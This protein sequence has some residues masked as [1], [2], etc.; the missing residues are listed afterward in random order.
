[1][2][3]DAFADIL[4]LIIWGFIAIDLYNG[5]VDITKDIHK[6]SVRHRISN[7]DGERALNE[8]FH[9]TPKPWHTSIK[10]ALQRKQGCADMAREIDLLFARVREDSY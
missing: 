10:L 3:L 5:N 6:A 9:A 4:D 2:K 1:V 7:I 8:P